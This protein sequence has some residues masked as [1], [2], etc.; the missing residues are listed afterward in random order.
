[1]AAITSARSGNWSEGATWVGGVAP[2]SVDTVTIATG[3][4]VT[5]D[6]VG[7]QA[8]AITYNVGSTLACSK[9]V[10]TSLTLQ[11][12]IT[13]QNPTGVQTHTLDFDLSADPNITCTIFLNGAGNAGNNA[14]ISFNQRGTVTFKGFP[15]KRNT[16]LVSG[17]NAGAT[18]AVVADTSGWQVGDK[19]V[20]AS[21]QAFNTVRQVD[22]VT[23]TSVSGGNI[24]WAGGVTYAHA[25]DGKVGNFS[26]NLTIRPFTDGTPAVVHH[27]NDSTSLPGQ[28]RPKVFSNLLF[29]EFGNNS[30][31]AASCLWFEIERSFTY[32]IEVTVDSCAFYSFRN[33]GVRTREL[34]SPIDILNCCFFS[35]KLNFVYGAAVY[36]QPNAFNP[37]GVTGCGVYA[38]RLQSSDAYNEFGGSGYAS[39]GG[40]FYIRNSFASSCG[41]SGA[42]LHCVETEVDSF[43]SFSNSRGLQFYLGT[44]KVKDSK[45][46]VH[47]GGAATNAV[48]EAYGWFG[49]GVIENTMTQPLSYVGLTA[50]T[51]AHKVT[52]LNK[53]NDVTQQEVNYR[54]CIVQRNNTE[55]KRSASSV[56]IKPT[57]TLTDSQRTVSIPCG[58]GQTIRIVGYVKADT[59]FYNGGGANWT[60]PTVTISGLGIT[61]VIFAASA[62]ANNAWEQFDLSATN[63]AGYDGNLTLTYTANAKAV[64]TGT[65]YFDGVPDAP[66]VTQ[67]RHY[68]FDLTQETS[69]TRTVDPYVVA[70]EATAA[71]YTGITID[72]TAKTIAFGAGTGDTAQEFYDYTRAWACL[73]LSKDI[74]LNRAGTLYSLAAGWTVIDPVLTGLTWGGETI[75]WNSAGVKTGSFSGNIFDLTAAGSYDF[76]TSTFSGTVEL[77]NTSGGAV[78]VDVPAGTS[79]TNTG[80]NITVNVAVDRA[81]ASII[82]IVPGSRLQIRNMTVAALDPLNPLAGEM[83]NTINAT[84]S[85]T[86]SYPTGTGYTAGDLIR[87]RLTYCSG[88]TAKKQEEYFTV[89]TAFGWSILAAQKDDDV[90]IA[91]G[92]DGS[93]VTEYSSDYAN[94]Q[95]D[96][97]DGDNTTSIQRGYAWYCDQ[98]TGDDGIRYF[99]GAFEAE[100]QFNYM[101]NTD[102]ADIKIHNT[103]ANGVT[104]TGGAVRRKDGSSPIA[105]GG[106][107]YI[108]YGRAYSD[109]IT[110]SGSNVI[111]GDIA[112][113]PAAVLA[114]LT[115]PTATDVADAVWAKELP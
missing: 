26:S 45:I 60:P 106:S 68:G 107:V 4:T 9:T 11:S 69:P 77:V 55:K 75:Q 29:H 56:S 63:T 79:Y 1:M 8:S 82:G 98:M 3:H 103:G 38:I 90:Y 31:R 71:A 52:W 13:A 41:G 66:F 46:G 64:T 109:V 44:F 15:R 101:L 39:Q 76:S 6:A 96:I 25:A 50:T 105:P 61:P 113:I 102:V 12:G 7:C 33:V 49:S 30:D 53:N 104:L 22:E 65:V 72:G 2:T 83:V 51:P 99:Y 84:G 67:C 57:R 93:T 86:Y 95:I 10:S 34:S 81:E 43:E 97:S 70:T 18:S 112:D 21:T 24:G 35:L 94:V 28:I 54:Q 85:Y 58:N 110:V 32:P 114:A 40:T 92:I 48:A 20:F 88:L 73:N 91:N 5:L 16:T 36:Y 111:T 108:Y 80:P 62:A 59:A 100:D 115:I 17:I 27:G 42:Y 23:L 47:N 14:R 89:A 19:I 37:G 87:V 74:P 78:V